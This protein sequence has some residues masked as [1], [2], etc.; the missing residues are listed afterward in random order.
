M[1][2][3]QLFF[4]QARRIAFR[5][6]PTNS[7]GN[8]RSSLAGRSLYWIVPESCS[9][10]NRSNRFWGIVKTEFAGETFKLLQDFDSLAAPLRIRGRFICHCNNGDA[11]G[12]L[13]HF[14]HYR[15]WT[16]MF[17]C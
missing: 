12:T 14:L 13:E 17:N 8:S 15:H 7:P 9:C 10:R 3:S 16:A 6:M 2:L 11:S 5:V 1:P 4:P